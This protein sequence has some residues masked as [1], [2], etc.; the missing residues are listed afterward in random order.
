MG[1]RQPWPSPPPAK[2]TAQRKF[3]IAALQGVTVDEAKDILGDT[4]NIGSAISTFRDQKGIEVVAFA[5]SGHPRVYVCVGF[6]R[7]NNKYRQTPGSVPVIEGLYR[8]GY[9]LV[10]SYARRSK[11]AETR[12]FYP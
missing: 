2:G 6:M 5:N 12:S 8:K 11:W 4:A 3:L 7:N 1:R 9:K 10:K